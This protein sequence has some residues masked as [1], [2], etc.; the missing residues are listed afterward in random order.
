MNPSALRP[1]TFVK[2]KNRVSNHKLHM[3]GQI[4][5]VCSCREWEFTA[6]D[7]RLRVDAHEDHVIE[8]SKVQEVK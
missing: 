4:T 7:R 2:S 8:M 3:V 5:A 1:L 6:I